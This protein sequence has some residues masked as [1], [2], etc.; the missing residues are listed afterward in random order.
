[1]SAGSAVITLAAGGLAGVITKSIYDLFDRKHRE[2]RE[3]QHRF[4]ALKQE[5]DAKLPSL[6]LDYWYALS[7]AEESE[8]QSGRSFQRWDGSRHT[9]PRLQNERGAV[10]G[11]DRTP[12]A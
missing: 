1:M 2:Q 11:P 10:A 6:Y 8:Q 4:A 7:E 9:I 12:R 5:L 3:D